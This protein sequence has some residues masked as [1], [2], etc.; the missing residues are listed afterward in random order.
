[1]PSKAI[2]K[3]QSEMTQNKADI[4]IHV[5]GG[6]LLQHLAENPQDAEKILTVDKTIGKSLDEMKREAGKKKV[7]SC[8]VLT[9]KEGFAIVLKYFG[10]TTTPK[11]ARVAA[12]IARADPAPTK[13]E[14]NF[15]IKL[16]DLL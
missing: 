12:P 10:I 7:G 2:E 5:V 9:D 11:T 15:D 16:E 3:L 8:A 1:M 13:P 14:I 6:F 4:Y